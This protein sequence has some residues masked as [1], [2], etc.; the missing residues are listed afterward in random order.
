MRADDARSGIHGQP[1]ALRRK[2]AP[3][4]CILPGLR[5]G[6]RALAQD[7]FQAANP[8]PRSVPLRVVTV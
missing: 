3:G 1:G 4:R 2:H 7:P 5:Q 6:D 8:G